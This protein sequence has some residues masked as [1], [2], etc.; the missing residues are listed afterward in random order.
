MAIR[1][2]QDVKEALSKACD[3]PRRGIPLTAEKLSD[4]LTVIGVSN[5]TPGTI[6]ML[7][8]EKEGYHRYLELDIDLAS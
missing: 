5:M 7:F 8:N 2:T 6:D 1:I 4:F 3:I